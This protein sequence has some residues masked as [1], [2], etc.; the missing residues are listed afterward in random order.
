MK[1]EERALELEAREAKHKAVSHAATE[2]DAQP[3]S[4][5]RGGEG[6]EPR[7]SGPRLD[8]EE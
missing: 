7:R 6:L 2:R 1:E 8:E 3:N 4:L 5:R